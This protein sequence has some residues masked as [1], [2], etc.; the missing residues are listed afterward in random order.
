ML[1]YLDPLL[2]EVPQVKPVR[3]GTFAGALRYRNLSSLEK[4]L[5]KLIGAPEG[6]FRDWNAIRAWANDLQEVHGLANGL[7]PTIVNV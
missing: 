7:R 2:K 6:D 3:I 1:A 4:M 5:M